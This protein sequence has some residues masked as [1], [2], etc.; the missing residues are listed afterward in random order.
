MDVVALTARL[1]RPEGK[2]GAAVATELASSVV[3][4][5]VL[6]DTA[7]GVGGLVWEVCDGR[8]VEP[9]QGNTKVCREK[10]GLGEAY[11]GMLASCA[12]S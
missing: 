3:L 1:L 8:R 7:D 6:V 9:V 10:T 5:R 12:A 2:W 11:G 4:G